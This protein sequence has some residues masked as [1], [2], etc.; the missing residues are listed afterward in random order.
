MEPRGYSLR[1]V[2]KGEEKSHNIQ[3]TEQARHH[4]SRAD[5]NGPIMRCRHLRSGLI[6]S[7]HGVLGVDFMEKREVRREALAAETNSTST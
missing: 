3:S 5:I 6:E 4:L 2:T 1:H 7:F